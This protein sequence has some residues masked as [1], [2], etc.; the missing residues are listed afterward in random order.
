MKVLWIC[1]ILFPEAEAL[2]LNKAAMTSSGGWMV[3]MAD[4]ISI[5][6]DIHLSVVTV[7]GKVHEMVELKG[8]TITYYILPAKGYALYWR[9]LAEHLSPDIVHIHGTETF[10]GMSYVSCVGVYNVVVSIQGLL[11]IIARYY[12]AG[13]TYREILSCMTIRDI[14]KGGI[15]RE[16]ALF[17]RNSQYETFLLEKVKYVI[18]RTTWDKDHVWA[19]NPKAQY[20]LCNEI[21]R[22]EFYMSR[23]WCYS[24]CRPHTIFLSQ[25]GYPLKGLHM[26]LKALPLI[27]RHY[28]DTI[29]RIAGKD[30]LSQNSLRDKLLL[31]SYANY[32]RKLIHDLSLSRHVQFTGPLN[33]EAMIEEYLSANVFVCPSSIEN[34]PN[35]LGEAQI[36]GVPCV[37]AYVGGIPDMVPDDACGFRYRFEEIEMMAK[38]ICKIFDLKDKY[39]NEKMINIATCRHDAEKNSKMLVAIYNTIINESGKH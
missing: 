19:I 3:G 34:S 17:K 24:K 11:S 18:G 15:C 25:G 30:L 22:K 39:D 6:D 37:S 7:S 9:K 2:L 4:K 16:R 27:M 14:Y 36:L 20:F 29:V 28:P 38:Y 1:N 33:A 31:T 5:L 10:W 26:L 13:L 23:K 35:S 12:F 32:I 21:L 8:N